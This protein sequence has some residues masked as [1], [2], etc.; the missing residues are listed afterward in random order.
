[1]IRQQVLLQKKLL[2]EK[3]FYRYHILQMY[4]KN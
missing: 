2:K 3:K 1:M 4:D